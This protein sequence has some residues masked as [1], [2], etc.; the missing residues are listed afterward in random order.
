[1]SQDAP[2]FPCAL[3]AGLSLHPCQT[4]LIGRCVSLISS[5][6]TNYHFCVIAS[7]ALS[8]TPPWFWTGIKF[9]TTTQIWGQSWL[10]NRKFPQFPSQTSIPMLT[11][12]CSSFPFMCPWVASVA[13]RI[14]SWRLVPFVC[15][16]KDRKME[17]CPQAASACGKIL[18]SGMSKSERRKGSEN[19]SG[20][21]IS[22]KYTIMY[23]W[24]TR[25]KW[26]LEPMGLVSLSEG[27]LEYFK[28]SLIPA[29]NL[30]P[31]TMP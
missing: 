16:P 31:S 15:F 19:L 14:C 20:L 4:I 1:M 10:F 21:D 29:Y 8:P 18:E 2:P 26:R 9:Q 17:P 5:P 27:V 23:V 12:S 24:P 28:G 30:S 25:L 11:P 6:M 22:R 13:S 7:F 3:W